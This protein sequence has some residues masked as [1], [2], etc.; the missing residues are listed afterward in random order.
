MRTVKVKVEC[1]R[2]HG[3]GETMTREKLVDSDGSEDIGATPQISGCLACNGEGTIEIEIPIANL[4]DTCPHCGKTFSIDRMFQKVNKCLQGRS[5]D[6]THWLGNK[7]KIVMDA[8][9]TRFVETE[10]KGQQRIELYN[11]YFEKWRVGNYHG[12][13]GKEEVKKIVDYLLEWLDKNG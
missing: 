5:Q 9:N 10:H 4:L 1:K 13:W 6:L 12:Y 11:T 7:G 8:N 2:C 3:Y